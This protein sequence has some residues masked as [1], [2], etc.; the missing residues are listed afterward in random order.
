V[1]YRYFLYIFG[2]ALVLG[3]S[4]A[5][6]MIERRP[7]SSFEQ[8]VWHISPDIG[9]ASASPYD[10]AYRYKYGLLSVSGRD[11]LRFSAFK[12]HAGNPLNSSCSYRIEGS[13]GYAG[14]WSLHSRQRQENL[15][16][17]QSTK[18]LNSLE[19]LQNA[20]RDFVILAANAPRPGNWLPTPVSGNFELV[21][22][23]YEAPFIKDALS[24]SIALPHIVRE[25]CQ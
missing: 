19:M 21:L 24:E 8:G 20:E 14:W 1:S 11:T 3:L 6:Y 13:V 22:S 4:S 9:E 10:R 17:W 23:V 25:V 7:F 16:G 12:D 5:A 2:L 15:H 18:G